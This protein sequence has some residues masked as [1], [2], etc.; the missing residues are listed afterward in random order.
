MPTLAE[1][2]EADI[3]ERQSVLFEIER[4]LF[5]GRYNISKKHLDIFS[6]QSIAMIY[7]IWEGFIQ[8]AF[9]NYIEE[10]NIKQLNNRL[11]KDEL[12]IYHI[13]KAFPQFYDYPSK[14]TR[15]IS[16]H[17]RLNGFFDDK[18]LK[19]K[20]GVSTQSN[21][22]FDVLNVLMKSFCLE[23]FSENW[24]YYTYPN[25]NLKDSLT[26]FLRYRNAVSHGGDISSEDKVT[27]DVFE[28]YKNLVLDL[29][30]EIEHR[31]LS[32]IENNCFMK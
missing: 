22:S 18:K 26:S 6:V 8:N 32:G 20:P 7:S 1:K 31:M 4:V 11:V 2:L 15:K 21:V 14:Q 24:K 9:N 30:C 25:I 17:Q 27:H 3:E 19:I 13:E 16:F 5:V 28:K 12:Y 10:I 29:M 23:A